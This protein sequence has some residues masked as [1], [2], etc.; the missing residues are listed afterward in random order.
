MYLDVLSVFM[1]VH[2]CKCTV[3]KE[4]RRGQGIT[5]NQLGC[6]DTKVLLQGWF[7]GV[8]VPALKENKGV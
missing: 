8:Q 6:C 4:A 7:V 2:R 3:P 5:C 1:S